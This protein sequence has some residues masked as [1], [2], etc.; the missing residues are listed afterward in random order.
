MAKIMEKVTKVQAVSGVLK[1]LPGL[2]VKHPEDASTDVGSS[3]EATDRLRDVSWK[4]G[5][6]LELAHNLDSER[7]PSGS[8]K[9]LLPAGHQFNRHRFKASQR[10]GGFGSCHGR[11][12]IEAGFLEPK[13]IRN[14][15]Q[16]SRERGSWGRPVFF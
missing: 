5:C 2:V 10:Q 1:I 14:R 6:I 9:P 7:W 11:H 16:V 15:K 8:R 13:I 4:G 12:E 3:D